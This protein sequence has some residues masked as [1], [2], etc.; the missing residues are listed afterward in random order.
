MDGSR[1]SSDPALRES[2]TTGSE[3]RRPRLTAGGCPKG[4]TSARRERVNGCEK[5]PKS[6]SICFRRQPSRVDCTSD[7]TATA[8]SLQRLVSPHG[9]LL[10]KTLILPPSLPLKFCGFDPRISICHTS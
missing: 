3:R 1:W 7:A 10:P 5:R 8:R 4:E 9:V 2:D 6:Y